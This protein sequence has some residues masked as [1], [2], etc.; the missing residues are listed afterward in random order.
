M[1][2]LLAELDDQ[3][4]KEQAD[5]IPAIERIRQ[6][7]TLTK[8]RLDSCDPALVAISILD[9]LNNSLQP[10]ISETTA[11]RNNK[12]LAHL[13]NAN[14]HIDNILIYLSNIVVPLGSP[15]VDGIRESVSS[16]RRSVGQLLR[17]IEDEVQDLRTGLT[18]ANDGLKQ[19]ADEIKSQK[20]RADSVISNFQ[21]QFSA[22]ESQRRE[23]FQKSENERKSKSESL[24]AEKEKE[25]DAIIEEKDE[26]Y[27]ALFDKSKNALNELEQNS[28][29]KVENLINTINEN[30]TKAEELVGIITDTGMVGGYQR[31]ANQERMAALLWRI[32]AVASFGG[33]IYFAIEAFFSTLNIS[34]GWGHFAG[35]AFVAAACGVL[36]AYAAL[37]ADKHQKEERRS[38]RMELE[39]ASISPY[40]H[41][42]PEEDQ[43]EIK[44]DLAQRMFGKEE[45]TDRKV[46]KKTSGS[47]LDTL[48]LAIEAIN[49]F[50]KKQ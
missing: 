8:S 31:V 40:I 5:V 24:Y 50:A 38:R 7:L 46:D 33:L 32:G 42:L 20:Q 16:Y 2:N 13:H 43:I 48:K 25:W 26:L 15:D 21:E 23:D 28:H 14:T 41:E 22:A 49:N 17:K 29:A 37:Q 1:E 6:V 9:K 36:G 18:N 34:L 39:L 47:I 35:R 4:F 45:P 44:K 19:L 10:T 11:F 30:K 3:E 27:N 12:N